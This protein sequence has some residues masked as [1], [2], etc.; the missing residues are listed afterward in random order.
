MQPARAPPSTSRIFFQRPQRQG[1]PGV[2]PPGPGP[3]E[4]GAAPL[5]S[6][7]ADA[8][9]GLVLPVAP[10]APDTLLPPDEPKRHRRQCHTD[11]QKNRCNECKLNETLARGKL[12]ARERPRGK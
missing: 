9:D 8:G 10:K 6:R 5:G 7:R 11:Q 12:P 4:P 3:P 1:P 2:A